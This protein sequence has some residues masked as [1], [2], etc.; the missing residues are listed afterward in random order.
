MPAI[1]HHD[2]SI[3]PPQQ[4]NTLRTNMTATITPPQ[5]ALARDVADRFA[6]SDEAR[7]LLRPDHKPAQFFALLGR[8]ELFRDAVRFA[9]H[10]LPKRQAIWWGCLCAWELFRP[11]T[12]PAEESAF[13]T[14]VDWVRE[15]SEAHRRAALSAAQT[16]GTRTLSRPLAMAVF[17]AEGS[18]SPP[19]CP[20]VEPDEN[21][22][23]LFVAAAV[24]LAGQ[25][26]PRRHRTTFQH[27]FL[28]LAADLSQGHGLWDEPSA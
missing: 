23:A 5:P 10:Y 4:R 6:L 21:Q 8:R 7:A 11:Q 15:P 28:E 25:L 3:K 14:V 17:S 20:I 2:S 27:H 16:A 18:L 22:T 19:D 1:Q 13:R 12:P 9:A 26:A 24:I